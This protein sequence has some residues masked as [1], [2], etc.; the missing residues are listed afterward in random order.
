M[1]PK[2][3]IVI[4]FH[5]MKDWQVYLTRCLAS[6]EAQTFKDYEI[7]L[8]KHSTM[9]VTSNRVMESA[10]GEIVKVIYMDDYLAHGNSL[11]EIVDAFGSDTTWL[12]TGCVHDR[13]DGEQINYH[14]AK[15]SDNIHTGNNTIGSPSVLAVRR[16]AMEYFDA[17]L[18]WLLDC[19][20]Y[21]RLHEKYGLPTI[22]DTPNVVIGL[23]KGQMSNIMSDELKAKEVEYLKKKYDK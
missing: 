2:I 1:K 23:H 18:S 6:I 5:W 4:P 20:L 8:L 19:D 22:L 9:P 13:G 12:V 21:K 3:S 17:Q 16:S 14:T 7:I 11:Q 15:Y 10:S